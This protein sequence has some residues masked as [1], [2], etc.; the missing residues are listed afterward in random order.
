[1]WEL[2]LKAFGVG[3][4]LGD[5]GRAGLL[6]GHP[7]HLRTTKHGTSLPADSS[8]GLLATVKQGALKKG[9]FSRK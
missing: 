7:V 3:S 5:A 6:T 9:V 2:T 8:A 4:A 1:M